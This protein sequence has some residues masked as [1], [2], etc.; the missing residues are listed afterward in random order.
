LGLGHRECN[1]RRAA[2][3]CPPRDVV[4]GPNC[5]RH[6][7]SSRPRGETQ[8]RGGAILTTNHG[9]PI[10]DNQNT[11]KAGAALLEDFVPRETIFHFDH[12]HIP[13]RIFHAVKPEA[14]R[15]FPQAASAHDTFWDFIPRMPESLHMSM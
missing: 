9:V 12:E 10:S 15:G 13:E 6:C 3:P 4:A 14:D 1:R 5:R 11:L 2:E 8:Q 7:S